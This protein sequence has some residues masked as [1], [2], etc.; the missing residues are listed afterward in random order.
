VITAFFGKSKFRLGA[1]FVS[2]AAAKKITLDDLST[3]LTRHSLCDWGEIADAQRRLNRTA[4]RLGGQITSMF[5]SSNG[6]KFCIVTDWNQ[7]TTSV[8][9]SEEK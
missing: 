9:L 6:I 8:I 5:I 2:D 7:S 4:L 1:L 3:A